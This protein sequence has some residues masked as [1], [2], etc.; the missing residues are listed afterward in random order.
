MHAMND[1]TSSSLLASSR[2]RRRNA[3]G[4]AMVEGALIFPIMAFFLVYLELAHHSF[5]GYLLAEHVAE[6]RTWSSATAGGFSGC[7]PARDDTNY[8]P[9]YLK[10]QPTGSGGAAGAAGDENKGTPPATDSGG[11]RING[12]ALA[13]SGPGGFFMHHDTAAVQVTVKRGSVTYDGTAHMPAARSKVFCNQPWL[14]SIIDI[15]SRAL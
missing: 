5:D 7:S 10:L 3:R 14:G 8:H 1:K 11:G 4:V 15:I 9:P 13:G 12:G 2:R 6:E